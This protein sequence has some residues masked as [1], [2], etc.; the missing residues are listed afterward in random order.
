MMRWSLAAL[1]LLSACSSAPER[2]P[3]A[4]TPGILEV[5]ILAKGIE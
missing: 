2:A 3:A 4:A 5:R 1:A